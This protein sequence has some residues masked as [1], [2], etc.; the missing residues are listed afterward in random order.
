VAPVVEG[1]L[2]LDPVGHLLPGT[3]HCQDGTQ[4][5]GVSRREGRRLRREGSH[6]GQRCG[7]GYC[8]GVSEWQEGGDVRGPTRQRLSRLHSEFDCWLPDAA[9]AVKSSSTGGVVDCGPGVV[10][11]GTRGEEGIPCWAARARARS[12]V[13]ARRICLSTKHQHRVHTRVHT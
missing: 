5:V 8:H 2:S 1:V 11:E 4:P 13:R 6:S 10:V 12:L 3:A 9:P 7:K